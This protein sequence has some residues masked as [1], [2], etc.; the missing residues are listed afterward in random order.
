[1]NHTPGPWWSEGAFV[2]AAPEPLPDGRKRQRTIAHVWG[3]DP[4]TPNLSLIAAAPD[5]LAAAELFARAFDSRS[6][7][8]A[9]TTAEA[10]IAKARGES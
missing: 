8:D 5:L 7:A 6:L 10:A 1:M 4:G 9:R 3:T 2:V